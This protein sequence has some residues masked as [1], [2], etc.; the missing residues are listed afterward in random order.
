[1]KRL[2][3]FA[4]VAAIAVGCAAGYAISP[5]GAISAQRG[6]DPNLVNG[7]HQPP[8]FKSVI[9][10]PQLRQPV[11]MWPNQPKD[12]TYWSID[13]I[14]AAHETLSAAHKSGKK[15]DPNAT[16]HDFPYWTRTHS[17]FIYHT[18]HNE[19]GQTAHQHVGYSQ[20]IV[21][22]GGRGT[23]VAGGQLQ[24][25]AVL[26]EA[27]RPIPGELRGTSIA[28]GETFEL[29][30]GDWVSIP[31]NTPAQFKADVGGLTYMVMKVNA[32]LYPWDL[33]R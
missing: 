12:A 20:F 1:M 15:I 14:R 9:P 2:S 29:K 4:L 6:S 11:P 26:M 7:Q 27:G 23:V 16:L 24:R 19:A 3:N 13:D 21:I 17:L 30:E 32:M 28:G 22:M 18:A 8:E 10:A 33:I 5:V 31:A 25:P